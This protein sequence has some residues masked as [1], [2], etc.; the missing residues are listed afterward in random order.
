MLLAPKLVL[1]LMAPQAQFFSGHDPWL[2]GSTALLLQD[3]TWGCWVQELLAQ[4]LA[5]KLLLLLLHWMIH[6]HI[7]AGHPP[8]KEQP[9][10]AVSYDTKLASQCIIYHLDDWWLMIVRIWIN[11][12]NQHLQARLNHQC[13]KLRVLL[14]LHRQILYFLQYIQYVYIV[15]Q[16][17]C[18]LIILSN[19]TLL[20]DLL[21]LKLV[22]IFLVECWKFRRRKPHIHYFIVHVV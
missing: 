3:V 13:W 4:K 11:N 8:L 12:L 7:P 21:F 10:K 20:M 17:R 14:L 1:V 16:N 2:H 15:L 9:S 22:W 19:G 18:I 6:D 5:Q